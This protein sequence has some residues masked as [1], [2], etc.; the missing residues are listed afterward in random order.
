[1]GLLLTL[2]CMS[3]Y[4]GKQYLSCWEFI[5]EYYAGGGVEV[6]E[7][8]YLATMFSAA[9]EPETGD[10]VLIDGA[11][12]CGIYADGHILHHT[13]ALGVIRDRA[14]TFTAAT[15][16]RPCLGGNTQRS[17]QAGRQKHI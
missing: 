9:P 14:D 13:N 7:H 8:A 1:M 15:Y 17:D 12:H 5:R 10:L 3:D 4:I 11:A 16:Y 2:G 6:P